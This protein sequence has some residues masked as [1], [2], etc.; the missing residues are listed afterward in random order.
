MPSPEPSRRPRW[1]AIAARVALVTF[2]LTLLSFAVT[3]LLSIIGLLIV[4]RL[5]GA[6]PDLRF[7]YRHIAFPVALAVGSIVLVLSLV[8]EVRHYRQAKALAG[9]LRASR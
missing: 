7:A 6:T 5:H 1:Y 8:V 4:S 9:I 2:L 3:L